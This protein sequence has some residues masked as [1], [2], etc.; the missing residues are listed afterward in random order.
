MRITIKDIARELNVHHSTVSRA[1][2]DGSAHKG[3]DRVNYPEL[4]QGA[5]LLC[6]SERAQIKEQSAECDCPDCSKH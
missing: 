6:Q 5:W 4:C 3:R 2:A 1:Y